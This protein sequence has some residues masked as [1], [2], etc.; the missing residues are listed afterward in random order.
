MARGR[1]TGGR[2]R[3]TLNKRT[4]EQF[5]RAGRVMDF[6]EEKFLLSDIKKLT[7]WQ[8]VSLYRDLMEFKSP[9]LRRVDDYVSATI[10]DLSNQDIIFE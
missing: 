4:S 6:I 1:K 10:N 8:R 2:G 9:K 7:P 5:D 3:G